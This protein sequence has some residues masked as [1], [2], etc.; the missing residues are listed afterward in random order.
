M[1]AQLE[2][3]IVTTDLLDLEHFSPELGQG[4]FDL[5]LRSFVFMAGIGVR[6]RRRQGATVQLAVGGQREGQQHHEGTGHHVLGQRARQLAAQCLHRESDTLFRNDI[7]HQAFRS[8]VV[9][10]RQYHGVFHAGALAQPGFDLA[11]FD[12]E[13]TDLHLIVVTPQVIHGAVGTPARQV[14][15]AVEQGC[16]IGAERIGDEFLS[17]QFRTVQVA[18]RHTVA[19]DVQLARHAHRH[20]LLV[21]IQHVDTGVADRMTNRDTALAHALDFVSG[22][23]SRG[24]GR[25]IAVEQMLRCA[26][27]QHPGDHRRIQ[28]IATHDQVTQLLEHRQQAV[29]V[30]MEQPGGHPQHAD[31]LLGQQRRESLLGQQHI[32]LDHH[33]ATTVEQWRPHVQG[34]GIEGR[35]RGE[36]H[37][38]LLVEI[39]VAVVDHQAVDRPVRHQHTLRHPGGTG[40]VHDVRH[41]LGILGQV[42]VVGRLVQFDEIQVHPLHTFR[43]NHRAQGQQQLCTTVLDHELLALERCVDIQRHVDGGTL[44]HGQ[45]TDQQVGRT[46]QANGH[47]VAQLSTQTNQVTGQA[48]G[49]GI[50]FAVGQALLVMDHGNRVGM[51][52][53]LC[54]EQAVDGPVPWIAARG[55]V[56]VC[57]H[58]LTL[59]RRQHR[60][61]VQARLRC[62]LQRLHQTLQRDVHVGA[63]PLRT[64]LRHGQRRQA[65]TFA[66]V[67]HRQGQWVVGTLF[68]AQGFDPFP[69]GQDLTR[70]LVHR[71]V[72]VVEQRAEQRHRRNHTAAALGQRQGGV[73]MPQQ[74][75]QPGVGGFHA[76]T[77]ALV[78]HVHP[79]RQGI[80]EH[81]QRP[82]SAIAALHPAHQDGAEH[83]IPF[84]TH[85]AQHLPPRQVDQAGR[86]HAELARLG[87][88]AQAHRQVDRQPGLLDIPS[89]PLHILETERQGRLVH[90][91]EHLAEERFVFGVTH[92]QASL[93]HIVAIRHGRRQRLGLA[94][95]VRLHLVSHHFHGGVVQR[96]MVEQQHRH[97][98]LVGRVLGEHQAHHRRPG[99]IETVMPWIETLLQQ[100]N[101]ISRPGCQHH[102][103]HRQ[104]RVA[105]DHLHRRIES[106]PH[107]AGAQDVMAVDDMLQRIREGRQPIPTA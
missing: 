41:R 105:P 5:A 28:H 74:A 33:H 4:G 39:G 10:P 25:A 65:E 83:H 80:D 17:G 81:T 86:T 1:T 93:G 62:L 97:P 55:R 54:F 68:V 101:D 42:Q 56:E 91:T 18:V 96:H 46:C 21:R 48:V 36:R 77:H 15:G 92:P 24:L 19:A 40:G 49:P 94:Q 71:A 53:H 20:R 50:E 88:Q 31:R 98:T 75:G 102:L 52:L 104:R 58:L 67:I 73:F 34:T 16:R 106:L 11:Q 60:Q 51:R 35:V 3:V 63:D 6:V 66:Q 78:A 107:H 64:D 7:P 70:V 47:A 14:A 100:S 89:I 22:G 76:V 72:T 27:F 85:L 61:A 8:I 99:D 103:I 69:T 29:S 32:L 37:P 30:L 82:I 2:E 13:A 90:I 79:Q 9:L 57:Q 59:G 43:H 45:L 44:E 87:P 95:Q 84:P 38:V 26:V 12:A 23:E